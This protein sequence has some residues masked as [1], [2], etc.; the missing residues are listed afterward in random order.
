MW[1]NWVSDRPYPEMAV[2][3]YTSS[4]VENLIHLHHS[5]S[6]SLALLL[7]VAVVTSDPGGRWMAQSLIVEAGTVCRKPKIKYHLNRYMFNHGT[8]KANFS[9]PWP[10]C[11]T[12]L[13]SFKSGSQPCIIYDSAEI[14]NANTFFLWNKSYRVLLEPW[15]PPGALNWVQLVLCSVFLS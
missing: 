2:H 1:W 8:L 13:V 4:K 9:V 15:W 5:L 14:I 11:T 10:K 7:P 6:A 12:D 3:I